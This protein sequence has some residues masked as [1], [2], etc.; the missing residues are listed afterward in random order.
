MKAARQTMVGLE[1]FPKGHVHIVFFRW[2]AEWN[3]YR[4]TVWIRKRG[5]L[6]GPPLRPHERRS[7]HIR[8]RRRLT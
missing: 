8:L 6:G 4:G 3:P 1:T 2:I 5:L 7:Y